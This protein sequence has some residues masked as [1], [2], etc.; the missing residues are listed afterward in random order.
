MDTVG[1]LAAKPKI[2]GTLRTEV[3]A[4]SPVTLACETKAND[5]PTWK[6]K[7]NNS[8]FLKTAVQEQMSSATNFTLE[9]AMAA[10]SGLYTCTAYFADTN[11]TAVNHTSVLVVYSK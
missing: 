7:F 1:L 6:W 10:N 5:L 2:F 8:Y 9:S 11:Q 4:G 3:Q